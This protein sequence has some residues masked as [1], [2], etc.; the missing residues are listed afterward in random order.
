MAEGLLATSGTGLFYAGLIGN[1]GAD[2]GLAWSGSTNSRFRFVTTDAGGTVGIELGRFEWTG[3]SNGYLGVG[4]W[5]GLT[6]IPDERLDL[7]DRTIR[8]RHFMASPPVGSGT[9]YD[10]TT[11]PLVDRFLA[12][13]PADGR[14]YWKTL[15][16]GCDWQV[17]GA[18]SDVVTAY[19]GNPCPPQDAANVG[20]GTSTPFAKL[21][22][23]R[24][25]S[26]QPLLDIGILIRLST[27]SANNTGLASEVT[28]AASGFNFGVTGTADNGGRDY[29]V[30]GSALNTGFNVGVFGLAERYTCPDWA[31]G[32]WG[33]V[34]NFDPTCSD[35]WAGYFEGD[36]QTIGTSWATGAHFTGSDAILKTNVQALSGALST[37]AQL[38]PRTYEYL[39]NDFPLMGFPAG[40]HPGFIAQEL[41]AVLPEL[42]RQTNVAAR[43]DSLG[44]ETTPALPLKAVNYDG[45]IPY[46]VA[47]MQ[48][49]QAQIAGLQ[50]QL[51]NCCAIDDG[52]RMQHGTGI[53]YIDNALQPSAQ[54]NAPLTKDDLVVIPNPFQDNPTISYRIG[55]TGRAQLRVSSSEGRDMGLL[56]D[57]GMQAGQHTLVWNTSGMAVGTYW[58]TLTLDGVRITEQAVKVH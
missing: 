52:T 36:I 31:V 35:A 5:A 7:T 2:I 4:D 38:Q 29:G 48:E 3:V 45:L 16:N 49:Q 50:Q 40:S 41:E 44:N 53:G 10:R 23:E 22:L 54:A 56:F 51:A 55:T 12:A 30:A 19:T 58:L 47:G 42:V 39:V 46:L 17:L 20:I 6:L 34:D 11:D 21:Q 57:A 13:D 27:P 37:I 18:N 33:R 26:T 32:V 28:G 9:D 43:F 15:S 24:N 14:V 8:L 1:T 25:A